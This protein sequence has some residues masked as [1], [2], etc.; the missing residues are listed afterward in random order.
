MLLRACIYQ[1]F[2]I[3][4][5]QPNLGTC[6]ERFFS[7]FF[8]E[9]SLSL[10]LSF[11]YVLNVVIRSLHRLNFPFSLYCVSDL[12]LDLTACFT[13]VFCCCFYL[14]VRNPTISCGSD[15]RWQG[16]MPICGKKVDTFCFTFSFPRQIP[17]QLDFVYVSF[18]CGCQ[19]LGRFQIPFQGRLN[20]VEWRIHIGWN[21]QFFHGNVLNND[22]GK[23]KRTENDSVIGPRK[24]A[25]FVIG[26]SQA[27]EGEGGITNC[28]FKLVLKAKDKD[29]EKEEDR[30]AESR[31][32]TYSL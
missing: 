21:N 9:T 14:P 30:T 27:R 4:V 1:L 8:P 12:L 31:D 16:D 15:G 20:K 32:E 19:R 6:G 22:T 26:A 29:R 5:Q 24:R 11:F 23:K 18:V 28:N 10:S 3:L 25:D 2:S 13:Y 17:L 7:P